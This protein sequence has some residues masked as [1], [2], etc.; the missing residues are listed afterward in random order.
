MKTFTDNAGR[1]WT[2]VLT[3][4]EVKRVKALLPGADLMA[5]VADGT[6]LERIG[7]DFVF[8]C[9]VVYAVVKPQADALKVTDEDFGRAM[10]GD[11]LEKAATALVEELVDFFPEAKRRLLAKAW[12]KLRNLHTTVT[13][14]VM[15]ELDSPELDNRLKDEI[16]AFFARGK[17]STNSPASPGSTPAP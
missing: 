14:R 4:N 16:E 3:V 2:I 17:A 6:L 13:D 7:N 12:A 10:A 5:G 9:D 15:T 1:T 8:M 11:C